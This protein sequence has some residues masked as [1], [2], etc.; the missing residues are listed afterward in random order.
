VK[1]LIAD[2]LPK[3]LV[4]SLREEGAEVE[5]QPEL[6]ADKLGGALADVDVL[7]VRGKKVSAQA[8]AQAP[9]L[10]LIVRAGA[11]VDTIDVAAASARGIYVS[12]CPGKNAVA[13]AE[14]TMGLLLAIDRRLADQARELREGRWNKKAYSKA[15]G[16]LGKSIGI[17]G[18]GPIALAVLERAKAFGLKPHMYSRSLT[19]E[20]AARFGVTRAASVKELAERVDILSL[21][22]PLTPE[23]KGLVSREVFS[24]MRPNSI[25]INTGRAGLVDAAALKEALAAKRVRV[26][27]DV[28]HDEPGT[29]D[30]P[31]NDEIGK[32][33]DVV[34]AHHVGASTEQAQSAIAEEAARVV[35]SFLRTGEVPNCVNIAQKTPARWQL[36]VR[37]YD[38]VGVLA[39]VLGAVKKHAINAQEISNTIFEG[40]IAAC[41]KI[42]LDQR[43]PE[44]LLDEIRGLKDE[45]IQVECAPIP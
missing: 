2:S 7:V 41:A 24:A 22:L 37:H 26:G 33:P 30:G 43:P 9:R 11:G 10:S 8:I 44:A 20:E 3:P 36:I 16:L 32:S 17:V 18:K 23:T 6:P 13:V 45:V 38:R 27:L 39:N 35:R 40:A 31:F 42:Q 15:D 4:A 12:N 34:G 14:L 19:E 28:Y 21:H 25:L 5:H 29:P 1:I